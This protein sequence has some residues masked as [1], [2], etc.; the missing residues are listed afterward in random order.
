MKRHAGFTMVELLVVIAILGIMSVTALPL[1]HTYQQR[2]YG[3]EAALMLKQILDAEIMYFL[4]NDVFFPTQVGE[5]III[6]H[7]GAPDLPDGIVI[8]DIKNALKITIPAGHFLNFDIVNTST[9]PGKSCQVNISSFGNFPLFK[10]GSPS[11]TA[12]VD[13]NGKIDIL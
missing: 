5:R 13:H 6:Y 2:A 12:D 1:Y 9:P 3:S 4:E 8:D 11:I 7:S 10:D